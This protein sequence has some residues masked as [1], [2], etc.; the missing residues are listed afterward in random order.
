MSVSGH[1]YSEGT[2]TWE[3]SLSPTS[4]NQRPAGAPCTDC[5]T[6]AQPLPGAQGQGWA[7]RAFPRVEQSLSHLD[8]LLALL[9]PGSGAR[10]RASGK[11]NQST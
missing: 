1:P 11:R 9:G 5:M 4:V 2:P 6:P 8:S 3:T 10:A 7:G